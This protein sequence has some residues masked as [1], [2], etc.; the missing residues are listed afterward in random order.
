MGG[1]L[2]LLQSNKGSGNGQF[3]HSFPRCALMAR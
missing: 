1:D 2:T 3:I